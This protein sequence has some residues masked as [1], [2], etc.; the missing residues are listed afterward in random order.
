[1]AAGCPVVASDVGGV[2]KVIDDGKNG[3]LVAPRNPQQ[4]AAAVIRLLGDAELRNRYAIGG[5]NKM[6][7]HFSAE[8]MTRQYENL[9]LR[10][11]GC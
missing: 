10:A 6:Q 3:L 7:D 2:S 9:Y 11:G 8:S 1:M 4:I 5:L